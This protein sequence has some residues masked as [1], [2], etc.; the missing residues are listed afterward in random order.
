MNR[1][2][3]PREPGLGDSLQLAEFFPDKTRYK[4]GCKLSVRTGLFSAPKPPAGPRRS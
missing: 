3:P 1:C 4:A 2:G